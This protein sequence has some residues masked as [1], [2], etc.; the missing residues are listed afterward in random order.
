[1]AVR[2]AVFPVVFFGIF[3][4]LTIAFINRKKLLPNLEDITAKRKQEGS[5]KAQEIKRQLKEGVE[6]KRRS[7]QGKKP[8]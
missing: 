3:S 7:G 6:Q 4:S 5:D 2:V 1:M 8:S